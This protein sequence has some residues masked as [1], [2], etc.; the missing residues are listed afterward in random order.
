MLRSEDVD[1]DL[2][3]DI[4]EES[5]KFGQVINMYI[6]IENDDVRIFLHYSNSAGTICHIY[7]S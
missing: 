5:K 3:E 4:F 2:K 7:I 1:D 6:H